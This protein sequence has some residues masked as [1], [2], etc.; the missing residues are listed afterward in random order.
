M[1]KSEVGETLV[2]AL[3]EGKDAHFSALSDAASSDLGSRRS[4][5]VKHRVGRLCSMC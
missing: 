1:N 5:M 2:R 4:L 3:S